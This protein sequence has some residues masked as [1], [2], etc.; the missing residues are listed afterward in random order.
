MKEITRIGP[1][2]VG[3]ITA[4]IGAVFGFVVGLAWALLGSA[5]A[6]VIHVGAWLVQIIGSTLVCALIAFVVGV[7]YAAIYNLIADRVGGIRIELDE[8]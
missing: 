3:R 2:S 7:I 8:V 4:V 6:V 5:I 1:L